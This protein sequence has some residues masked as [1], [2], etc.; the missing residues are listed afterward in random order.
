MADPERRRDGSR[1]ETAGGSDDALGSL[2]RLRNRWRGPR[3][4]KVLNNKKRRGGRMRKEKKEKKEKKKNLF[5]SV[6][7]CWLIWHLRGRRRRRR[8]GR[9]K[10]EYSFVTCLPCLVGQS[11][12]CSKQDPHIN[13]SEFIR[14]PES[15]PPPPPSPPSTLLCNTLSTSN[16]VEWR[17]FW[18][19]AHI[20]RTDNRLILI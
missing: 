3:L 13:Y 8:G 7:N 14:N 5:F 12:Q 10:E 15:P 17:V 16:N 9:R 6:R 1:R 4:F 11:H 2:R 18:N 19:F 20:L